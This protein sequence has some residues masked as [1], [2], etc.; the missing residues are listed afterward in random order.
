MAIEEKELWITF[1]PMTVKHYED[2]G[3]KFPRWTNKE[4]RVGK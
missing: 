3:Y 1:S 4:G 2:K